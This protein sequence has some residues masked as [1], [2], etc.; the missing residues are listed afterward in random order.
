MAP[1]FKRRTV[2]APTLLG[3][4]LIAAGAAACAAAAVL[5]AEPFLAA[6]DRIPADVLVVEAWMKEDGAR[7]AAAEIAA[8]PGS[9]RCVVV[10]GGLTGE[11]WDRQRWSEVDIV[12]RELNRL[13]AAGLAVVPALADDVPRGRTQAAARAAQAALTAQEIVPHGINVLTRDTHARRSRLTF[14]RVF[15]GASAVGVISW[16]PPFP[17]GQHWWQSTQRASEILKETTAYAGELASP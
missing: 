1:L 12:I 6:S 13:G 5:S 4:T 17:P 14:A 2:W 8:H 15:R 10:A 3:S 9:Y 7:A 16:R 11:P